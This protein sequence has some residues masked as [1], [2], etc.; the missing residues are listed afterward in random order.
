VIL[1]WAYQETNAHLAAPLL[2]LIAREGAIVPAIW[3]MEIANSLELSVLRRRI[4]SVQYEQLL[5]DIQLLGI[6]V[7]E[8]LP[9]R[10]CRDVA[11]LARRHQLTIYDAQYLETAIRQKLALATFD[12]QLASAGRAAGVTVLP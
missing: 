10:I 3:P 1:S 7:E 8:T 4:S 9:D 12:E 6:E 11:P 2:G 5:A